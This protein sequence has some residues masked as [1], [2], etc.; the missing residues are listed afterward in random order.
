MLENPLSCKFDPQVLACTQGSDPASCLTPPQVEGV[1]RIYAGPSNP[2]TGEHIFAGLERGS[3]LGWNPVP[4]GYA[5]DYFK[6]IVFKDPNWDPKT[7]N[8]DSARR[9][10]EHG[11][12]SDLRCH[13][14]RYQPVHAAGREAD[15]VSGL[16]GARHPAGQPREVLRPDSSRRR[17]A[18]RT[19]F[20]SSW[21]PGWGTAEAATARAPSTWLPRSTAGGMAARRRSRSTHPG[22]ATARS[23]AHARCAR[24]QR[25]QAQVH[26]GALAA[27]TMRLNFVCDA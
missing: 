10:R 11:S 7:L 4:V 20:E 19:R 9:A 3:E 17:A 13:E 24:G 12:Q 27:S 5:V 18:R 2:K 26:R 1:R 22:F 21:C 6:Y 23:I 25:D 8:Y 15:H 16:G 14:R